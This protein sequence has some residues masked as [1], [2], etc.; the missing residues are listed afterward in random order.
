MPKRHPDLIVLDEADLAESGTWQLI[1]NSF[2][3]TKILGLTATPERL[4]GKGLRRT[5][6]KMILG[7]SP[8]WMMDNGFIARPIYMPF[9]YGEQLDIKGLTTV[10]DIAKKVDEKPRIVGDTVSHYLAY[11]QGLPFLGSAITIAQCEK[12]SDAWNA[13][14]IRSEII[15]SKLPD[16]EQERLFKALKEK[17]IRGLW[18][19]DMMGRGVDV[20]SIK[21]LCCARPTNSLAWWLQLLGRA[22]RKDGELRP[23]IADHVGNLFRHGTVE[24]QREWSLEGVSKTKRDKELLT[25]IT[26]CPN[27]FAVYA[28]APCCPHCGSQAAAQKEREL[29]RKEGELK[30]MQAKEIERI[31][32]EKIQAK[33]AQSGAGSLE[34]LIKVGIARKM[35]HPAR[36]AKH[37]FEARKAK[38]F[39]KQRFTNLKK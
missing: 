15:H 2:P 4:D 9:E 28:K 16:S 25:Q 35:A 20:P 17:E 32:R 19:V 34:D 29:R 21:Y 22:I 13:A 6:D 24:M 7:P 18:S 33:K 37:V 36:W 27:C 5:F 12:F 11:G 10:E 8:A 23:I 39:E 30:E 14:G 38:D 31:A 26:Q 3:N 1:I